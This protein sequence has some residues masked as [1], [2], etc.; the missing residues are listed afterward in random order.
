VADFT[1]PHSAGQ[2]G[3]RR[4]TMATH[5]CLTQSY[6]NVMGI[7]LQS[8]MKVDEL[9]WKLQAIC[10]LLRPPSSFYEFD[11]SDYISHIGSRLAYPAKFLVAESIDLEVTADF[12]ILR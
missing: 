5:H 6:A 8:F 1:S 2:S 4:T 3:H 7:C 12:R 9:V 10:K 11:A